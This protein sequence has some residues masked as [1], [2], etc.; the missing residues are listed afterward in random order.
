MNGFGE[1]VI[2]TSGI[3]P[4]GIGYLAA[5]ATLVFGYQGYAEPR[6]RQD[7]D[8]RFRDEVVRQLENLKASVPGDTGGG[9]DIIKALEQV[10]SRV[11]QGPHGQFMLFFRSRS[12]PERDLDAL[13]A[14]DKSI[15]DAIDRLK[16]MITNKDVNQK[17]LDAAIDDL[18]RLAYER[19]RVIDQA[20]AA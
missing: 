19:E 12:I 18:D 2:G 17:D 15:F 5:L 11:L 6:A 1:N 3:G 14:Y 10:Q 16:D 13:Y 20:E 8:R 7:T 9:Q 4:T